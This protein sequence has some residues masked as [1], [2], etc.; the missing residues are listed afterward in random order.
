MRRL[1]RDAYTRCGGEE[2]ERLLQ[3]LAERRID[4]YTAAEALISAE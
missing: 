3:Q 2:F 4:P 1:E